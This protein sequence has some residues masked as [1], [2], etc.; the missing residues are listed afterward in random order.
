MATLFVSCS[1]GLEPFLTRELT[2]LGFDHERLRPSCRGVEV[3]GARF[4]DVY[5]INYCSRL[6]SRVLWPLAHFPCRDRQALYRAAAAIPWEELLPSDATI[7]IDANV[8]EG[9]REL[10]HSHFAALVVKDA[11]CDRL[12]ERRGFRPSVDRND[13]TVQLNLYVGERSAS[14]YWDTSGQPLHKRGYRQEGGEAPL[15]ETLAAAILMIGGYRGKGA[16]CDPMCGSGTLLIEAALIATATPPGFLRRQWGFMSHP[17][18]SQLEWLRCKNYADSKKKSL[19]PHETL[20]GV[21]RDHAAIAHCRGNLR[22]AGV[23][24]NVNLIHADCSLWQ[25]SPLFSFIAVNPPYGMRVDDR[26]IAPALE[27]FIA[28]HAEDK[29][30]VLV[31]VPANSSLAFSSLQLKRKASLSNGGIPVQLLQKL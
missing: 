18:F 27:N 20:Y 24:G 26:M 17:S 22:A 31:L 14:L 9:H 13:P 30:T 16:F 3:H 28:N 7:A 23:H 6:A 19:P 5:R 11:L 15:Q 25:G 29:A 10:R 12:R 4:T 1:R 8:A 2:T 21:E